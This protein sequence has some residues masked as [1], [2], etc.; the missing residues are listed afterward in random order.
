MNI[1]EPFHYSKSGLCPEEQYRSRGKQGPWTDIYATAATL[2]RAITGIIPPEAL[3]RMDEDILAPP[4]MLEPT[5]P[6]AGEKVMLKALALR[7]KNRYQSMDEFR[8]ALQ[9]S[10]QFQPGPDSG[11]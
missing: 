5:V 7:G 4:S 2:Y 9:R 8:Y 3:D 6:P 11:S 10:L 1:P